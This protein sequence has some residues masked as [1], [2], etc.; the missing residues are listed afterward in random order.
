MAKSEFVVDAQIGYTFQGGALEGLGVLFQASNLTNEPFVTYY[1]NDPRQIRDYQ[2]YGRNFM[3]G[4]T[5]KFCHD[6][7]ARSAEHTS[8]LQSLMLISYAVF[9]LIKH[10]K[11]QHH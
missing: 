8:E 7:R 5:Y 4:I 10:K 6:K 2:N 11:T 3:A 1:N 9:C